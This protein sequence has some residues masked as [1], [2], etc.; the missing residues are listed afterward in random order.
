[1]G[2][3]AEVSIKFKNQVTNEKKLEK[4]AET[5]KIINSTLKGMDT[6][7]A[8]QIDSSANDIKGIASSTK[9]LSKTASTLFNFSKIKLGIDIIKKLGAVISST[10]KKSFDFLENF[11]LFQVAFAGNYK[12]AER[13]INKMSEM[14]GL[15]ESWLTR[16]VGN[17]KQLTNAMNLTAE[18]G[19]KVSTLLTQMSLDISSLYNVDIDRAAETLRSAMAG[20]TKPIRGVT[21]GDI[22]QATLQT[23]LDQLGIEAAV[24]QLSYAEKR[25]LI[26]ISLTK[27][28]NAS[29]GDMG[30]T[31]E[32]PANQLR[33]MN[34]QWERLTRAVGNV[35]LPLLSKIL[36]YLNAILMVLTEIIS[37]IATLIG[38]KLE[39]FDY[40]DSAA[41]GAWDLDEGLQS[42]G[43]SAKKLKQGLR[44]FDKLNVI[45]SA[46]TGGSG[47]GGS[48]GGI[49][50]KI[51]EA[52]NAAFDEYQ[53]KLDNVEMKA[54]RIRDRIMEWLGFTKQVDEKTGDVSFKYEGLNGVVGTIYEILSNAFDIITGGKLEFIKLGLEGLGKILETVKDLN[55]PSYSKVDVLENLSDSKNIERLKPVQQAFEKL[56]QTITNISYDNLALTKKEKKKII[57]SINGLTSSLKTALNNYVT[58]QI[59]KLNFLYKETGVI[60]EKEYNERLKE[61]DNFQKD[62]EDKIDKQGEKLKKKVGTIYDENGNIIIDKYAEYLDELDKYELQSYQELVIGED[63][64]KKVFQTTYDDIKEN[65]IQHFSELLQGYAKDR[66]DAITK[67]EEKRDGTIKAAEELYGKESETYDRIKKK[68][69]ETFESEKKSAEKNY[70]D[71]YTSFKNNQGDLAKYID[72]DTGK[73]LTKWEKFCKNIHDTWEKWTTVTIKASVTG[74]SGQGHG[75]GGARHGATGGVFTPNGQKLD[76]RRFASGGLPPVGQMFIAREKG[77][78]LVGQIGNHTAVMNNDQIVASVASGVY[79]AVYKAN[80]NSKSSQTINPTIIVQVGDKEIAKQVITDLQ[81]MAKTN[82]KPITIGG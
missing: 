20:Q 58:E 39:D 26:I 19:E 25:L 64:K 71:I 67:A 76:V 46:K 35:F 21:G 82:G 54:T 48:I 22:T 81:D 43:A 15:D 17:F 38:F 13:F 45:S 49:N 65:Q 74:S 10:S 52:F 41:T 5:L 1:M 44:G 31:I 40:F 55:S 2:N 50:P 78:E 34:E 53:K 70:N 8:K 32:S 60:T 79:D 16:T 24:N 72:K 69:E 7:M 29:I 11:N 66:D 73:V 80:L 4:Y 77:A 37:A 33:I 63:D 3:D 56:R 59:K 61:L 18:M 68:A 30:R 9:D 75:S 42:A 14:Y 27:Q 57:D 28:L 36:P 62:E 6:G 51:L 23:T 12:S 47:S